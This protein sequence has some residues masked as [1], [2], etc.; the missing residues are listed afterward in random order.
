MARSPSQLGPSLR[1]LHFNPRMH[2][3]PRQE[4]FAITDMPSLLEQSAA[5]D[6]AAEEKLWS[7][8]YAE[9]HR[10][11]RRAVA[12]ERPSPDLQVSGVANEAFLRI[13][14]NGF[15]EWK[16]PRYFV[17]TLAR[18][19]EQY[20]LDRA[21][22]RGRIKRGDG[23][24]PLT[25]GVVPGELASYERTI[26]PDCEALLEAL[27]KLE[28]DSPR[29]AEITRMRFVLDLSAQETADLLDISLSTVKREWSYARAFFLRELKHPVAELDASGEEPHDE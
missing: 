11:A 18:A 29:A 21:R 10:L 19:I 1:L 14:R 2:L 26:G 27:I 16:G 3:D 6:A 9:L 15:P 23:V 12:R 22:T 20:L 17:A 28:Q 5:G 4:H 8:V 24:R 25:L 13:F 7:V